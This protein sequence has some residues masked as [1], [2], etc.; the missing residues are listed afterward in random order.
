[1]HFLL[2]ISLV[3]SYT[4]KSSCSVCASPCVCVKL[5][6]RYGGQQTM[7]KRG[8]S[9]RPSQRRTLCYGLLLLALILTVSAFV[10]AP[11]DLGGS[12]GLNL[13]ML[14]ATSTPTATRVVP[15]TPTATST[16]TNTPLT[17]NTP[18]STPTRTNTPTATSTPTRTN[19]PL[20]TNTPTRTSTSVPS[21]VPTATTAPVQTNA[22]ATP[23]PSALPTQTPLAPSATPTATP[24][25]TATLPST[26]LSLTWILVGLGLVVLLFGA[27]ALR[28][29][30]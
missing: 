24:I 11:T 26:G 1:M 20:S 23:E 15:P 16:P 25:P 3:L 7:F 18:T 12:T 17:T 22:T 4:L 14:Q 13:P 9:M 8:I 10:N 21:A 6:E 30:S 28:Q 19:T 29:S 5:C 2:D 27:R